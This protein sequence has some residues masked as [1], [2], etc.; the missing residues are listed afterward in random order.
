MD[1]PQRLKAGDVMV[2]TI[3]RIGALTNRIGG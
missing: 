1:P 2:C 3:D